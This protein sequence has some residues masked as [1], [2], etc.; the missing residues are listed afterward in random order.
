MA[1]KE[2]KGYK[3]EKRRIMTALREATP[4]TEDYRKLLIS[5][6]GLETTHNLE[7]TRSVTGD[8]VAKCITQAV[9]TGVLMLFECENPIR[10]KLLS[11]IPKMI[12]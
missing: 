12:R 3:E 4:G 1:Q 7:K 5:L 6:N 9:S 2:K 10:S 8:T 11:F